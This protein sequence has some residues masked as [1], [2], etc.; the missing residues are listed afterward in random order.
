M[1]KELKGCFLESLLQSSFSYCCC[2]IFLNFSTKVGYDFDGWDATFPLGVTED[3]TV[4]ASWKAALENCTVEY[5][6]SKL[7]HYCS[8]G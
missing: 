6:G 2:D 4:T 7:N 8:M 5:Y 1:T 3:I